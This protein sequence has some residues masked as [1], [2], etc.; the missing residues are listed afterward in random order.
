MWR[1]AFLLIPTIAGADSFG[2]FSGVDRHY[3]VNQ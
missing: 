1:A 3:V 2:G